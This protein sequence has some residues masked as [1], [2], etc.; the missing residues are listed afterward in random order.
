M[1][2]VD[3]DDFDDCGQVFFK[4]H[5]KVDNIALVRACE[6]ISHM[7]G[8]EVLDELDN[9]VGV[10]HEARGVALGV[11]LRHRVQ[12]VLEHKRPKLAVC[13]GRHHVH[14]LADTHRG[15]EVGTDRGCSVELHVFL[16]AR[17]GL[18]DDVAVV[19]GKLQYFTAEVLIHTDTPQELH[20]SLQMT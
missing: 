19:L 18:Q 4:D 3:F 6:L 16:G 1:E 11:I 20:H 10:L 7:R 5:E 2:R 8:E 9:P 14:E 13:V 12:L 15:P 17:G